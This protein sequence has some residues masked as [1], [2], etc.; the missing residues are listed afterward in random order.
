MTFPLKSRAC[1][2]CVRVI[3]Y[4]DKV[5]VESAELKFMT[6][7]FGAEP[8][9]ASSG[10]KSARSRGGIPNAVRIV[11]TGGKQFPAACS[12]GAARIRWK[13]KCRKSQG[14]S[15]AIHNRN[16]NANNSSTKVGASCPWHPGYI[17]SPTIKA[18][19]SPTWSIKPPSNGQLTI[20]PDSSAPRRPA[21]YPPVE[22]PVTLS[23]P[24]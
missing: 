24:N 16:K 13:M 3:R 19:K 22:L 18:N 12:R 4:R 6:R 2:E 21:P 20:S 23:Q 7:R 9:V 15:D 8:E 5:S 14:R 10:S 11:T 1:T 17:S